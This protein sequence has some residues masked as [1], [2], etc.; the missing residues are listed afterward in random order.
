MEKLRAELK[1]LLN[2]Y[3]IGHDL[4]ADANCRCLYGAKSHLEMDIMRHLKANYNVKPRED[5]HGE[6]PRP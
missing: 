3:S 2:K 4:P 5:L 6:P 1:Q